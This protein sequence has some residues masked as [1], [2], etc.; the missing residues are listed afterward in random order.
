MFYR[1]IVAS[2]LLSSALTVEIEEPESEPKLA[3]TI[4]NNSIV[5]KTDV[6]FFNGDGIEIYR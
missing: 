1:L 3:K 5:C 6:M 4:E 2:L